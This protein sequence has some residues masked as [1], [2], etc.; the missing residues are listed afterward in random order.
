MSDQP[1]NTIKSEVIHK[2]GNDAPMTVIVDL[3]PDCYSVDLDKTKE[4]YRCRHCGSIST[5]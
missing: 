3:C 2:I 1:K 5:N 4:L